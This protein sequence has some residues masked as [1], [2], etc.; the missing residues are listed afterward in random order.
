MG[1]SLGDQI[2]AS[3]NIMDAAAPSGS[4]IILVPAPLKAGGCVV[5][6]SCVWGHGIVKQA[7]KG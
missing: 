4:L 7:Q 2:S 6:D 5:S 3:S 1:W